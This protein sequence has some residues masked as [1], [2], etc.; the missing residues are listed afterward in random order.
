MTFTERVKSITREHAMPKIFD[1]FLNDNFFTYRV[2]GNGKKFSSYSA[3][4]T[5]KI[6]KNEQGGSFSGLDTLDTGTAETRVRMEYEPK[7]AS[8][9]VAIPGLEESV[10][11]TEAQVVSLLSAE[12]ESSANDLMDD[13]ATMFYGDGTGNNGKDFDGL[14]NINDDGTTA[15]NVGGLSRTTYPTLASTRTSFS[16]TLTLAK[17]AT[18]FTNVSGGSA[19]RQRPT[20]IL[21]SEAERDYYEQLLTPT[22]V[23]NYQANGYPMVT[24]TSRGPISAAQL[25]GGHGFVSVIFKGVPWVG[26]EQAPAGTVWVNN[27]N[28]W[29]WL[30]L[31]GAR[32]E[33]FS[34]K[35]VIDG[36]YD[37]MPSK[38]SGLQWGGFKEPTNQYGVVGH[39][40]LLGNNTS[41]APRRHGRGTSVNGV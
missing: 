15:A 19:R 33:S 38:N 34:S 4:G 31:K 29:D 37:E 5:I 27:E 41:F 36:V 14:D 40:Y 39:I 25:K 32:L 16:G 13:V 1:N 26:D 21:S 12:M 22:V 8:K 7:G 17:M 9:P 2:V 18:L 6:A 28:Y 3:K 10:N 24:R 23:A 35:S 20:I 11:S 30:G